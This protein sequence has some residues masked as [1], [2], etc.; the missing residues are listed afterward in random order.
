MTR[1]AK[2]ARRFASVLIAATLP[3]TLVA[4]SAPPPSSSATNSAQAQALPAEAATTGPTD[5]LASGRGNLGQASQLGAVTVLIESQEGIGGNVEFYAPGAKLPTAVV[6]K[7]QNAA[8]FRS[9]VELPPGEYDVRGTTHDGRGGRFTATLDRKN[10]QVAGGV[11]TQVIAR[12]ALSAG[13]QGLGVTAVRTNAVGLTW[14][15]GEGNRA[16]IR[17]TPGSAPARSLGDGVSVPTSGNTAWDGGLAA[18][19]TYT[20]TAFSLGGDGSLSEGAPTSLTVHTFD[21]VA[22]LGER[23]GSDT[24][25]FVTNQGTIL[26][27]PTASFEIASATPAVQRALDSETEGT[28]AVAVVTLPADLTAPVIGTVLVLPPTPAIPNGFWGK[29]AMV[30]K[31]GRTVTLER[32]E[33]EDVYSFLRFKVTSETFNREF[34]DAANDNGGV[35]SSSSGQSLVPTEPFRSGAPVGNPTTSIR[36]LGAT[37]SAPMSHRRVLMSKASNLRTGVATEDPASPAPDGPPQPAGKD[38]WPEKPEMTPAEKAKAMEGKLKVSEVKGCETSGLEVKVSLKGNGS[39]PMPVGLEDP[40]FEI[41]FGSFV[42]SAATHVLSWV[43]LVEEPTPPDYHIRLI[44]KVEGKLKVGASGGVTCSYTALSWSKPFMAGPIPMRFDFKAAIALTFE[45]QFGFEVDVMAKAGFIVST[46][47][48]SKWVADASSGQLT[49]SLTGDAG[50]AAKVAAAIG[51]AT[52]NLNG[53]APYE[54]SLM[55]RA[56]VT[57]YQGWASTGNLLAKLQGRSNVSCIEYGEGWAVSGL[58][59]RALAK[60]GPLELSLER[61][62][63]MLSDKGTFGGEKVKYFPAS[64]KQGYRWGLEKL[65]ATGR[66]LFQPSPELQSTTPD[67]P[68]V[69]VKDAKVCVQVKLTSNVGKDDLCTTTNDKGEYSLKPDLQDSLSANLRIYVDRPGYTA[70]PYAFNTFDR[71]PRGFDFV[72]REN[73]WI[74]G[75]IRDESGAK[76]ASASSSSTSSSSTQAP[77]D[78]LSVCARSTDEAAPRCTRTTSD[79]TFRLPLQPGLSYSYS[80]TEPQVAAEKGWYFEGGL[81]AASNA[82]STDVQ[83][84]ARQLKQH[85][86][87]LTTTF[88]RPPTGS[89]G[90]TAAGVT[91][92][93]TNVVFSSKSC[94]RT[95][96]TGAAAVQFFARDGDDMEVEPSLD[97]ALVKLD[98]PATAERLSAANVVLGDSTFHFTA[99]DSALP[100]LDIVVRPAQTVSVYAN[101]LQDQERAALADAKVCTMAKDSPETCWPFVDDGTR[102]A[103]RI[104]AWPGAAA[105]E[106]RGVK[107]GFGTTFGD[108]PATLDP[109][110]NRAMEFKVMSG[111][112]TAKGGKLVLR[113]VQYNGEGAEPAPVPGLQFCSADGCGTGSARAATDD[114]GELIWVL[115]SQKSE[116]W[117]YNLYPDL[118]PALSAWST[119]WSIDTAAMEAERPADRAHD[120]WNSSFSRVQLRAGMPYQVVTLRLRPNAV[121]NGMVRS[122]ASG[123]DLAQIRVCADP[124]STPDRLRQLRRL[125]SEPNANG[126][127]RIEGLSPATRYAIEA[128]GLPVG[129]SLRRVM[130]IDEARMGLK[131][132]ALTDVTIE[133][134]KTSKILSMQLVGQPADSPTSQIFPPSSAGP[135]ASS[136]K[137]PGGDGA[138]VGDSPEASDPSSAATSTTAPG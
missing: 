51:P 25:T 1:A 88:S 37:V 8:L 48:E 78:A 60:A 80:V 113:V 28:T 32:A 64:C 33:L 23:A 36:A 136:A 20:Y 15:I 123:V 91:V 129:V 85:I 13:V 54:L 66:V 90:F 9:T 58:S 137:P 62:V 40:A 50:V 95:D 2:R 55:A 120:P 96:A 102:V 56:S 24:P 115:P 135:P 84:I 118:N 6:A 11:E 107:E 49:M 128:D 59:F 68:P 112:W 16:E 67:A 34:M 82:Y 52:P 121:F 42:V 45:A 19:Q 41:S 75:S 76:V 87:N 92:C 73:R 94:S 12:Y 7:P 83:L 43:N 46:H 26:V 110:T 122:A 5:S 30:G 133:R 106:L 101:S 138:L 109:L 89:V 17:R 38:V 116:A 10:I 126:I 53:K 79:G 70:S 18:D 61:E 35:I 44:P 119:S 27:P 63:A 72:L 71:D 31:T 114:N 108:L 104:P 127:V 22:T 81:V 125:C 21:S 29:V 47:E 132:D 131:S 57:P 69:P 134:T 86:V 124:P 100:V 65:A 98:T 77:I 39:M 99:G 97:G 4:C 105:Y 103:A 111:S 74:N 93:A 117:T 3:L 130:G 14:S